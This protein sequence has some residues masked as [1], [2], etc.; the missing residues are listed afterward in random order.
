MIRKLLIGLV[1]AV[2]G[3]AVMSVAFAAVGGKGNFNDGD[4]QSAAAAI[5]LS[6]LT[7]GAAYDVWLITDDGS[8]K[9]PLGKVTACEDG[10]SSFA[11]T[12]A[13]REKLINSYATL[14]VTDSSGNAVATDTIPAGSLAHIRH[15]VSSWAPAPGGTGLAEGA[16]SQADV[17]LI[18]SRLSQSSAASGNLAGAKQHAEHVINIIEGSSGTNFGDRDG[19]G[20]TQ[21]PG[22]GFGVLTYASNAAK[23][24][25]FAMSA[26]GADAEVLLHGK[27]VVDTSNNV[28]TWS[29]MARDKAMAVIAASSASDA[30]TL[31][32]EAVKY[33][34][35]ASQG[36][37]ANGD[38]AV[39]PI[40]GEGGAN[41]AYVHGQLMAQ[42]TLVATAK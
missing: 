33:A 35:W 5:S 3:A 31:L 2:L 34:R 36:Y 18:H 41:T 17:A 25:A 30:K 28:V 20:Q 4:A 32:D 26:T 16:R 23:H 40:T 24:A 1:G 10:T 14:T 15:V 6:G 11:Y 9:L 38:G 21:N 8:G 19:N 39:A 22:D 13:D 42:L 7:A 12:S 37:D 29:G 27:H